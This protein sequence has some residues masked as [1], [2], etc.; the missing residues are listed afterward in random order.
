MADASRPGR[1]DRTL[2]AEPVQ[3]GPV[4]ARNHLH[5]AGT[6]RTTPTRS[7]TPALG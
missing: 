1:A 3:L 6:G 4:T 2:L 7:A 5:A